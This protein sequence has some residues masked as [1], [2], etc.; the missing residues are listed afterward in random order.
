MNCREARRLLLAEGPPSSR[1]TADRSEL[2]AHLAGCPR[3]E[4]LR[5]ELDEASA[6]WRQR[7]M[8]A[9]LPDVDREWRAVRARLAPGEGAPAGASRR[10]L[11]WFALPV[12]GAAIAALAFVWVWRGVA[13]AEPRVPAAQAARVAPAEAWFVE[14]PESDAS[15]VVFVDEESGWLVVWAVNGPLAGGI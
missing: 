2:A 6:Q 15:P 11:G 14:V 4:K 7:V 13:P 8:S 1:L 12:A 5:V 10:A 9:E 3:C